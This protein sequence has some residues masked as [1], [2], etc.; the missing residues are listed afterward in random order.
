MCWSTTRA[1]N[2]PGGRYEWEPDVFEESVALN[3][4]G[5][6]RL[7][8]GVR[9]ALRTSSNAGGASVVNV[10]SMSL[11]CSAGRSCLATDQA[12][13]GCCSSRGTWPCWRAPDAI[14]VNAIAP[15]VIE[16]RMTAPMKNIP[17]LFDE[18]LNARADGTLG[19]GRTKVVP[20]VLYLCSEQ[21][22]TSRVTALAVD[23]GYLIH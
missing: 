9:D 17:A 18:T 1:R 7:T 19:N 6:F 21:A 11:T 22:T 13:P 15:G 10:V 4:S 20:V 14:R 3:P 12:R 16:T 8:T 2:F 23:G 5:A